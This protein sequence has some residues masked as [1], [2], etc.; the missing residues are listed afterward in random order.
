MMLKTLGMVGTTY[1]KSGQD[2]LSA[3]SFSDSE[4]D[5]ALRALHDACGVRESVYVATCNRVE[6]LFVGGSSVDMSVYRTRFADFFA[7][8]LNISRET[9]LPML[10]VYGGE[11]ACE[12]LFVVASSLDSMNPGEAQIL[13]QVK[14]AYG[15]AQR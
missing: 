8:R 1:R 6:L 4:R 10:H 14:E 3:L 12:H 2:L 5:V 7:A 15:C 9:L 13:G 11:G